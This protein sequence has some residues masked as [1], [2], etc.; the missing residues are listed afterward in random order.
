MDLKLKKKMLKKLIMERCLLKNMEINFINEYFELNH[1]LYMR[2]QNNHL[3]NISLIIFIYMYIKI[4]DF[5][6]KVF[7]DINLSNQIS[8]IFIF[9]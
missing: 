4:F 5:N 8:N 7:I 2:T 9:C 6:L 3:I 1:I